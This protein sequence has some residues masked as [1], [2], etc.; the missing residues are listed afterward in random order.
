MIKKIIIAGLSLI[1]LLFVIN[2]SVGQT[3]TDFVE[4]HIEIDNN[5]GNAFELGANASEVI[6]GPE[7]FASGQ[8]LV[9]YLFS[10]FNTTSCLYQRLFLYFY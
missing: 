8:F 7:N 9:D 10:N 5:A 3:N 6:L 1:L 2:H 4:L